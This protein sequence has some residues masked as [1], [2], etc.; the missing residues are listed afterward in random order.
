MPDADSSVRRRSV[1]A[2]AATAMAGLAGCTRVLGHA[3]DGASDVGRNATAGG[4][5]DGS[6]TVSMLA[7]GSLNNAIENGLGPAVDATIQVEAHGSARVARLVAEGQKDPDV[8]SVSDVALFDS[9]LHPD[10]YVEFA[11][12][13]VVVAYNA[14]TEGG[15]RV[16]D[17]GADGWYRPLLSGEVSLGR[18]DPDLD[19]LGYRTLFALELATDHYGTDANLR[20]A[21]PAKRQI[22]PETQLVSQFE[23]GAIDAAFTYRNMAAER[24]YDYVELPPEIDLSDPDRTEAYATADYEL[25]SG[26][27]VEGGLISYG[28]TLR[29]HSP[30]A[31]AVF[32]AHVAGDYLSDFGFVIPDEYPRYT[33]DVPDAVAD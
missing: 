7:A 27:V 16:A 10:W 9:P 8:V 20:E 23:T 5:D 22:Y 3:G 26:K 13:S 31:R 12:N 17:A 19:P 4:G 21:I 14:D 18:T 11:T 6:A 2:G 1:L 32:D 25:P 15:R 24:G 28:S 29:H 30:A 33:G